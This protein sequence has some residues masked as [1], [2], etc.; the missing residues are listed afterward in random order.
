PQPGDD[1]FGGQGQFGAAAPAGEGVLS[2]AAADSAAARGHRL[3][4]PRDDRLPRPP[5]GGDRGGAAHVEQS[6]GA[7]AG[8]RPDHARGD[9]AHRRDEDPGAEAGAGQVAVRCGD[10]RCASR[11]GEVA[12]QGADLLVPQRAAPLGPEEPAP[13]AV[14]PVQHPH[15]QGRVGA[16]V[17]VVQLD[18]A[19]HLAVHL[20]REHPGAVAVFRAGTPGGRARR[21]ADHGRRRAFA[22]ARGRNASAAPGPVPHAGLLSAH[23]RDRIGRRHAGKDHRRDAGRHHVRAPGPGDRPGSFGVD[24][25]EKAGGLLLMRDSDATLPPA[26]GA[27]AAVAQYLQQHE[28]KD[29]L[30]FITCGSVD[31]GKSTLIGRLLHDTKLLFDDQLAALEA[32]SRRHGTQGQDI[33]FALL[34]DGLAAEREQGI[35]I[36]V[37]YRFFS[38]EKRKSIV[39]DCPRHEQYTRNMATGASTADL[40]VVLVDARKG[41][42]T[43][44]RRHSYIVSLSGIKNVLLAVNKMDLVGHDQATF[45]RIVAEYQQLATTLGIDHITALPVSG[46]VGD[47]VIAAS[48]NT[49]WYGGPSLLAHLESVDLDAPRRSGFSRDPARAKQEDEGARSRL[50]PLLQDTPFRL[51]VQWVCRPDQDFRGFTGQVAAGTVAVGD[52]VVVLPAGKTA[53]V[54]RLQ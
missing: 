34:V 2:G 29:L 24:G 11:R 13:G 14:E 1:V 5:G 19:G 43:Q 46:L 31:D 49:P 3:E 10:R 37:A 32:D 4:V 35:T 45:D 38:T 47:N 39:A 33:D 53:N 17:P 26:D 30:R 28:T 9:G 20:P 12:R 36:D 54:T 27:V 50:K 22:D 6:R 25:E 15:P 41:L 21:R 48:A 18:R 23:R 16:G 7:G 44:T 40:A 51:P 8:H 52:A 42:L